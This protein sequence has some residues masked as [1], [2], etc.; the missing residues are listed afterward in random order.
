MIKL[1]A[2]DLDGTLL[3]NGA[4]ELTP[5]ALD[6]VRRLTEKGIVF[7]ASSGRQ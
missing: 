7:V 3:Q 1:V 4:Q 5:R 2:S 6:L